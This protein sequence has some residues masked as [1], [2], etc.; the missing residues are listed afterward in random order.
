[1]VEAILQPETGV[2][3][4]VLDIGCGSGIWTISMANKFPHVEVIGI[5]LAP[6]IAS[7]HTIPDNCRFE[8]DDV[9]RGLPRFYGQIDLIHM[10]GI[11]FGIVNYSGTVGELVKCLKP[12]GILILAEGEVEWYKED[13]VHLATSADP[14]C[15]DATQPG[16]TWIGHNVY[17]TG[18]ASPARGV[19]L[20][21][22]LQLVDHGLWDHPS[23][24]PE[25]CGIISA[26]S[27]MGPWPE[28]ANPEEQERLRFMGTLNA[29]TMREIQGGFNNMFREN[30][31]PERVVEH[32]HHMVELE[33]QS[34][35]VVS[36]WLVYRH[37]WGR[38][39]LA[40]GTSAPHIPVQGLPYRP[41][42]PHVGGETPPHDPFGPHGKY[43]IV[44]YYPTAERA[45]QWMEWKAMERARLGREPRPDVAP[46]Q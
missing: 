43:P 19:D 4:K 34:C 38:K 41:I 46:W 42:P 22:T 1:M 27:P 10:R 33:L 30:G 40:D 23:M 32:W 35:D 5:D 16:K 12:G 7:E 6:V 28:S 45:H 18:K 20:Y 9:N 26:F 44:H 36:L 29:Q 24:D 31:I 11:G 14:D 2:E 13:Q 15:P 17:E 39:L 3:K 21:Q 37:V 8:L 25:S